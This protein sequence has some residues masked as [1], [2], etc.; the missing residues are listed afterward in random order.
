VT[1]EQVLQA[2]LLGEE[3]PQGDLLR[4]QTHLLWTIAKESEHL[5]AN[6]QALMKAQGVA[7]PDPNGPAGG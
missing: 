7:V 4:L 3:V 2:F 1:P 5:C 6:L